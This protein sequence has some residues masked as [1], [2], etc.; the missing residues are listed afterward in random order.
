MRGRLRGRCASTLNRSST[1]SLH[2]AG[3][4]EN[5]FVTNHLSAPQHPT[6]DVYVENDKSILI[7]RNYKNGNPQLDSTNDSYP[8]HPS[9]I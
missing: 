4:I 5:F 8:K 9:L 1:F 2:L 3:A 7:C 6:A